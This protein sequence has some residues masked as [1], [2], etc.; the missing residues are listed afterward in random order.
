MKKAPDDHLPP[1]R[2][3]PRF[4]IE[5]TLS[6]EDLMA[7]LKAAL[8]AKDA[9][10]KGQVN[11]GYATFYFPKEAQ[12]Y[13]SPQ[14]NITFEENDNGC[15]I[16]GLY[17]PRPAVWTMFIFFYGM[18]AFA[19]VVIAVIGYSNFSLGNSAAIFYW[20][21]VLIVVFLSLYFVAFTGQKMGHDE[22]LILQGFMEEVLSVP[23]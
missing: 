10:C 3:R 9:P 2:V 21:P 23:R 14:L 1:Y 5:T 13:W 20:I 15:L 16:R 7:K 8:Q 6:M 18:I 12:H 17:G 4:E 19:I 22:M 11:Q